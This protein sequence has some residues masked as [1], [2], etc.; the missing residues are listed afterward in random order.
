MRNILDKRG[1]TVM[2][3]NGGSGKFAPMS[4]NASYLRA[5]RATFAGKLDSLNDN[6]LKIVI[7][8]SSIN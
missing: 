3:G 7:H 1:R 5:N 4:R 2:Q 6:E 8:P